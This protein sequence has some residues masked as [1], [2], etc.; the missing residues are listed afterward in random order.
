MINWVELFEKVSSILCEEEF[1]VPIWFG[2]DL[3]SISPPVIWFV[4]DREFI[5]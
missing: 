4:S 5:Y 2:L 1:S 3:E